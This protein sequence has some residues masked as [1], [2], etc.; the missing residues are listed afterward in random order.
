MRGVVL[1]VALLLCAGSAAKQPVYVVQRSALVPHV[2][3]P[4]RTGRPPDGVADLVA[5]DATFLVP[6]PPSA[7]AGAN[8]GLYVARTTVTVAIRVRV[9][10]NWDLGPRFEYAFTTGQMPVGAYHPVAPSWHTGAFGFGAG[11]GY[12]APL[13]GDGVRLGVAL[14]VMNYVIPYHEEGTCVANCEG[15][16]GTYVADGSHNVPVASFGI[17]PSWSTHGVTLFGGVTLRNHPS[18]TAINTQPSPVS[19]ADRQVSAGPGYWIVGMGAE[20]AMSRSWRARVELVQPLT[21]SPVD[22]GPALGVG[23]TAVLGAGAPRLASRTVPE[24]VEDRDRDGVGDDDDWC[25]DEAGPAS[26]G[27]CEASQPAD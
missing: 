6:I 19:D 20:V 23:L 26:N 18:N 11:V 17:Y 12:S 24:E 7:N 10:E 9:G 1:V 13:Y 8:A 4:S 15:V 25:P 5:Q 3:P 16:V 21:R 14:D 22:Y 2:A 27:G